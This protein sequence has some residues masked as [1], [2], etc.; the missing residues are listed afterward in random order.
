M[1]YIS[2]QLERAIRILALSASL[3]NSKDVPQWL[4]CSTNCTFN[5]HPN[6]RPAPLEL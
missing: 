5:F 6:L 3:G 4:G 2:S 1:R